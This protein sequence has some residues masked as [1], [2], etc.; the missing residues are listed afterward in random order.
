MHPPETKTLTLTEA[1]PGVKPPDDEIEI[2]EVEPEE[3]ERLVRELER[4]PAN[5]QETVDAAKAAA[6]L[7]MAGGVNPYVNKP[8]PRNMRPP[9]PNAVEARQKQ[10]EKAVAQRRARE[11]RAAAS[12]RRNRH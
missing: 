6:L 9:N 12:R 1:R 8:L 7:D 4:K 10:Q 5:T 11:K 2:R 3:Y